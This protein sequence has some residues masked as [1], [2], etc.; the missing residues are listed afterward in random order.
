MN[1]LFEMDERDYQAAWPSRETTT[2]RGII[3][4]KGKFA[5]QKSRKGEYKIPGGAPD[6]G[7]THN[8]ALCREV[9]EETGL[10]V[11]PETI[12]PLGYTVERRQDAFQQGLRFVRTTFFYACQV[13]EEVTETAMTESEEAL[14]FSLVWAG[15][16]EIIDGNRACRLARWNMR[17]TLFFEWL[18]EQKGRWV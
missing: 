3:R 15:I 13:G 4:R 10:L 1:L 2:V 11:R 16:N 6:L 17:D 9:R 14:G 5:M 8:E 12:R 18:R 7:E